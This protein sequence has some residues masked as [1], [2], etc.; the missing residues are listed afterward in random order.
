MLGLTGSIGSVRRMD[1]V[2]TSD[3]SQ[4]DAPGPVSFTDRDRISEVL[5]EAGFGDV[6]AR[7]IDSMA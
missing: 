1:I 4:D 7:P 6:I 2:N 5:A 3:P